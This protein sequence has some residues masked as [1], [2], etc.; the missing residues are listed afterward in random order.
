MTKRMAANDTTDTSKRHEL[1]PNHA[2]HQNA[3]DNLIPLPDA[4]LVQS[5]RGPATDAE[6]MGHVLGSGVSVLPPSV[7]SLLIRQKLRTMKQEGH[8]TPIARMV[9]ISAVCVPPPR[10]PSG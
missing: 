7:I 5:Y 3:L 6:F 9:D 4:S 1:A 10:T 2:L 8:E